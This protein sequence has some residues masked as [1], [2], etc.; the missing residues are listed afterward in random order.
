MRAIVAQNSVIS[1]IHKELSLLDRNIQAIKWL[2]RCLFFKPRLRFTKKI[3]SP[4]LIIAEQLKRD[5]LM[6]GQNE[7]LQHIPSSHAVIEIKFGI[8]WRFISILLKKLLYYNSTKKLMQYIS[9]LEY[10]KIRDQVKRLDEKVK[11]LISFNE[12]QYFEGLFIIAGNTQNLKTL[13]IAHGFYRD[14]GA[15]LSKTNTNVHNYTRL[16]ARYH[17]TF[18]QVQSLIMRKYSSSQKSYFDLGK[19]TLIMPKKKWTVNAAESNV[20]ILDTVELSETNREMI[21][22]VSGVKNLRVKKH[23]DDKN[24][25]DFKE[26]SSMSEINDPGNTIFWGCNST[27]M[28]QLGRAGYSVFLYKKSDFL[29]YIPSDSYCAIDG[30]YKISHFYDWKDFI[31]NT[32]IQYFHKLTDILERLIIEDNI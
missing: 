21:D 29:Q 5:D 15:K 14:T 32:G 20:L 8:H 23:P 26:L 25:Y 17:A 3:E 18:G 10:L 24:T 1:M 6:I 28:L 7:T 22:R 19:P 12:K 4:Y 16:N 13:S 30:F 9:L 11:I 27:T 31:N 2:I